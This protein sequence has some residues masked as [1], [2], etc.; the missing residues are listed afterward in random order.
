MDIFHESSM[1]IHEQ[2]LI[3]RGS[4]QTIPESSL[5]TPLCLQW[6]QR[7]SN[8]ALPPSSLRRIDPWKQLGPL[9]KLVQ[10]GS[11][12]RSIQ[13]LQH[14]LVALDGFPVLK[15]RHLKIGQHPSSSIEVH[16][17]EHPKL[18]CSGHLPRTGPMKPQP[19][20]FWQTRRRIPIFKET[21]RLCQGSQDGR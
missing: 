1:K 16:F 9:A 8:C 10:E 4:A 14:T 20:R 15:T 6:F 18:L 12:G 5:L 19:R 3:T 11:I 7:R 17:A 21:W 2:S 13:Q